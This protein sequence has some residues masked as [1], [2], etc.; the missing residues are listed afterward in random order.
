MACNNIEDI[1]K[2]CDTSS[3]GIYEAILID[4]DD[5]TAVNVD[6]T[7]HTVT[8]ITMTSG[9]TFSTIQFKRNVGSAVTTPTIDFAN[10]ST[11]YS[12]T[13]T[14]VLHKRE[15]S[16][17]RKLQ[18]LAEGQRYLSIIIKDAQ[19]KYWLYQ[20]AQLNGG[21]ESTGTAKADGSKYTVTFMSEEDNRPYEVSSSI[22]AGLL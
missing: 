6:T 20:Y 11:F 17:S 19:N 15:A 8:G 9:A 10:G 22:I 18:I 1:L 16:K 3:G 2:G 21:E 13:I 12:N 14:I 7:A 4:Q 5:V